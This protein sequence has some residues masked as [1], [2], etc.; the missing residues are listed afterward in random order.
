M[1]GEAVAGQG[2]SAADGDRILGPGQ[3]VGTEPNILWGEVAGYSLSSPTED[4]KAQREETNPPAGEATLRVPNGHRSQPSGGTHAR[5]HART[6]PWRWL[7]AWG[8]NC[9]ETF[10]ESGRPQC[11]RA[12]MVFFSTPR[13]PST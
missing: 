2:C 8:S 12:Y 9:S 6:W 5:T 3:A 7:L 1:Q 13:V 10:T 11:V 4:V